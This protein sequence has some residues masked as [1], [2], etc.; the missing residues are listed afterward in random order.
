M[1]KHTIQFI[2]HISGRIFAYALGAASKS[3]PAVA[4]A[5]IALCLIS[6]D[7]KQ[8]TDTKASLSVNTIPSG[9]SVYLLGKERGKTPLK[10]QL[11]PG[12]YVVKISKENYDTHYEKITVAPKSVKSIDTELVSV[13]APVMITSVPTGSTVV[14]NEKEIG[15]TPLTI[16]DLKVGSYSAIV[17]R[18]GYAQKEISWSVDGDRPKNVVAELAS[19][20]GTLKVASTPSNASIFIN[21]TPMGRTPFS[22]RL[23]QGQHKIRIE[24][25]GYSVYEF[26]ATVNRDKT[27]EIS[28]PLE[29]LPSNLVITSSPAGANVFVNDKPYGNTPTELKSIAPGVYNVR[30]EKEG[31]DRAEREVTVTAGQKFEVELNLDSNRGGL[32]VVVNPPGVTIYFDG[33]M[34]GVSE[35]DQDHPNMSKVFSLRN[36]SMGKH[37][38]T[39]AHKRAR[40]DKKT[41]EIDIAKGKIE[42]P[43]PV[44]M[45]I[46]NATVK[47]KNGTTYTGRLVSD[48]GD[49]IMFEPEPGIRQ[50]YKRSNVT[51]IQKLK[52]EE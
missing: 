1:K 31:F 19:N 11:N 26:V 32:D 49:E 34:V 28:A 37:T 22:E 16:L 3:A 44:N 52:I 30:I 10:L 15:I 14:F 27:T 29:Q 8:D 33:K 51:S 21:D 40:P 50:S 38:L 36:L 23:E 13:S 41:I 12:T 6:C 4:A 20:V 18:Q 25:E 17:K 24:R 43:I 46:A 5:F 7:K 42:R 35:A 47:L 45:W 39:F 48:S 9:A 2:R